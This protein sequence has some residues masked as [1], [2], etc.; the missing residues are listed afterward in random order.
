MRELFPSS[1]ESRKP[2]DFAKPSVNTVFWGAETIRNMGPKI[3]KSLPMDIKM[4]TSLNVFK[5]KIS[6]G[7]LNPVPVDFVKILYQV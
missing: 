2:R 3:W 5:L 1:Y 4:S 6:N 7:S